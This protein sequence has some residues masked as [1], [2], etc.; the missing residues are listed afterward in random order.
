[1]TSPSA[2]AEFLI[3]L[4]NGVTLPGA[5]LPVATLDQNSFAAGAD[6]GIQIRP[7]WNVDDG[8]RRTYIHARG[9]VQAE[10]VQ[11]PDIGQTLEF[12][13]P[14]PKGANA[15]SNLGLIL[16][17]TAFD[18]YGRRSL[19]VRTSDGPLILHQG[20]TELNSRYLKA[21]S[22]I[23]EKPISLDMRLPTSS[24]DSATFRRIFSQRIPQD[25]VDRRLDVLRFFMETKRYGDAYDELAR[26]I[27]DFPEESAQASQLPALVEQHALQLFDQ[28]EVRRD[29]GQPQLAKAILSEFPLSKV[30]R[31][32]RGRVERAISELNDIE[33]QCTELG[34]QL[35]TLVAMLDEPQAAELDEIVQE[36]RAHLSSATLAR[37]SDFARFGA[38][39][40]RSP[41]SRIALAVAGWL[42]GSGSGE[43]NLKIATA[44]IEV[45]R[46]VRAY[47]AEPTPARRG[48]LLNQLVGL[49]ASRAEYI[50]RML[51][52]MR[53]VLDR[54]PNAVPLSKQ[55]IAPE[56]TLAD[57]SVRGLFGC[58]G[59]VSD[60]EPVALT[61]S[62]IDNPGFLVQLPPEY[63]PRRSYPCVVALHAAGATPA[64][65][66]N[67]W[68]G[69]PSRRFLAK[70]S[71]DSDLDEDTDA[72]AIKDAD[73][74][75][76]APDRAIEPTMR[77]GNAMR[78]GFIVVTPLWTR[79]GQRQ[80]EFTPRE[81][82]IVLRSVR[83]AMRRFA[84]DAD[85][86][87]IA[88]HGAGATAAW[89]IALS[90]P[91]IWAGCVAINADPEKT[92]LH[93]D[94]TSDRIPIYLVIGDKDGRPLKRYG[95]V[96]DDYMTYD[97]DAMVVL[98][99]GRGRE[100]FTEES[101]RIFE[102]LMSSSHTR[103][104][105]PQKLEAASMREGDQFFWWLEW[106]KTLPAVLVDPILWDDA[107]RL[108]AAVV[109]STIT[110]NNEIVI[111]QAPAERFIIWIAP[112]MP[113]AFN[114]PI[115]VRYR[116]RRVDFQFD[117]RLDVLLEDVRTRADR[118]RPYWGKVAIP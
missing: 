82:A 114:Q 50:A 102:W 73:D 2:T 12:F 112:H 101:D 11:V 18:A 3:P 110:A 113:L 118:V 93:Y 70:E 56:D 80:Y 66:M 59:F 98:M 65:Q 100:F 49:E 6:G 44:L 117:G 4:R 63:D 29:A 38:D 52:L 105:P 28:A 22:L 62:P 54:S 51:P 83:A 81:H 67:W 13:Q 88:G 46:V 10:P 94:A 35:V 109:E 20:I 55:P 116:T 85:R 89:D 5:Y 64:T 8:L 58:G 53:P 90:H 23:G 111:N 61:Q 86:I 25:D 40:S 47:L 95:A 7:I 84:L 9:M 21:E 115:T 57:K 108:K 32:T 26:I 42:L 91:D 74:D 17:R 31:V 16:N 107:P 69:I 79:D 104:D 92:I 33:Q 78:H 72:V 39:E 48:Q 97:H 15:V 68:A 1:M 43:Q 106:E 14:V 24:I 27:K 75:A 41:D 36:I 99:R 76:H 87:F 77:L 60:G 96:Y 71:N 19:T 30:G 37:L 45:R 103:P 34:D